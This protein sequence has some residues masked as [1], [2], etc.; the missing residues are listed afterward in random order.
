MKRRAVCLLTNNE[1]KLPEYRKLFERYG[2]EVVRGPAERERSEAEVR[3]LLEDRPESRTRTIAVL[4]EESALVKHGR[5]EP[6]AMIELERV[7]N[8]TTLRVWTL[9][10]GALASRTYEHATEGW[11]DLS[12]RAPAGAE[13]VFG[14]DDVFVLRATGRTYHELRAGGFKVSSRDMVISAFLRDFIYYDSLVDL[15]WDPQRPERTIDFANSVAAF[16]AKNPHLQDPRVAACGL[17]NVL[18]AVLDEGVF[19]RAAKNRREKNYWLPGLNAG[20]PF[21]PKKDPIHEITHMTHDFGHFLIP[22]LIFTGTEAA[23]EA[24]RV[25][26]VHRM[27]GEATTLVLADMLF[28][29]ALARSGEDYDWTTRRIHPLFLDTGVDLSDP[30]RFKDEL[31][32]L[33]RANVRFVLRGDDAGYRALL[34]E[35]GK[36]TASL[37]RFREKY[38]PFFVEDFRWTERNHAHMSSRRDELRRWW[39]TAGPL[40]DRAR[41]RLETIDEFATALPEGGDL[42]D[43]VLERVL[44]T[45]IEPAFA[46]SAAPLPAAERLLRGFLRYM[47]G[48]LGVFFRFDFVPEAAT[49]RDRIVRFLEDAAARREIDLAR[50]EAVRG[51]YEQ[52]IDI[53]KEKS[54]ISLDDALTWTEV[55]P[56]FEPFYVFYDEG[57]ATYEDLAAVARRILAPA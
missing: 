30:A 49:Y 41:L 22:D 5:R 29:D 39:A 19:F 36:S 43:R 8:L 3:A 24:R 34:A 10:E 53:L 16:V 28:V 14:W 2:I 7:D 48:Q 44:A 40:R 52:F 37:E 1:R 6:A 32:R 27:I 11:V 25:Y 51:F 38:A 17:A 21:V 9:A 45:R 33:L 56:L 55:Y 46:G 20:I 26:I 31:R 23:P 18:E 54:L 4:R 13:E 15:G 50:I 57:F 12:R 35:S 42:V 47:L